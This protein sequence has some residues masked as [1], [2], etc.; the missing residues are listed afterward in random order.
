MC[1]P[2]H[3][4]D[5]RSPVDDRE[6][7][8]MHAVEVLQKP[9]HAFRIFERVV[10]KR[11]FDFPYLIGVASLYGESD[12]DMRRARAGPGNEA[13]AATLQIGDDARGQFEV[14]ALRRGEGG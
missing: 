7:I 1:A 9:F 14:E 13:R 3:D 6:E 10:A 5:V 12:F 4:L 11:N 2:G 8:L